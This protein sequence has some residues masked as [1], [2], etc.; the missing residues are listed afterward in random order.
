ME[1]KFNNPLVKCC[2]DMGCEL[3]INNLSNYVI[4]KGEKICK[5]RKMC[6]CIIF[7]GENNTIIIG[8]VELKNKTI[9]ANDIIKKLT[10]GS[11]IALDILKKCS[12][13][14]MKFYFCHI[15]LGKRWDSSEHKVITN[16]KIIIR[17]KKYNILTM[18]CGVSISKAISMVI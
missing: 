10:H 2:E 5:D 1:N 14:H 4:L 16:K 8:I 12:N 15:V 7:I 6:D 13:N 9:H 11:E 18:K 3:R 17:G